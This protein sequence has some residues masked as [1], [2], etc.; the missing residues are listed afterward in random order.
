MSLA[1]SAGLPRFPGNVDWSACWWKCNHGRPA[2]HRQQVSET[3]GAFWELVQQLLRSEGNVWCFISGAS[4]AMNALGMWDRIEEGTLATRG[5]SRRAER[6][7]A[8]TGLPLVSDFMILHDPPFYVQLAVPGL[9]GRLHVV[10]IRNYSLKLDTTDRDVMRLAEE[11]RRVASDMVLALA[12]SK[13]PALRPTAASTS[14]DWW[15]L[16]FL[17]HTVLV[18]TNDEAL[19]LERDAVQGGRCETFRLGKC[20]E[21]V[22]SVDIRSCYPAIAMSH[23]LPA[24]LLHYGVGGPPPIYPKCRQ[25]V[26]TIGD[27]TIEICSPVAPCKLMG[28]TCYPIGTFRT[29]LCGPELWLV[30]NHGRIVKW[31]RWATYELDTVLKDYLR[32]LWHLR[33]RAIG[34]GESAAS[35]LYKAM[36]NS[37]VGKF[38]QHGRYWERDPDKVAHKPYGTWHA[39]DRAGQQHT[40]RAIAWEPQRLVDHGETADSCPAIAAWIYSAARVLLWERMV[41]A[42]LDNV[43]YI[44]TDSLFVNRNGRDRLAALVNNDNP[45]PGELRDVA[46]PGELEVY[47]IKHYRH[48]GVTKKAGPVGL[49]PAGVPKDVAYVHTVKPRPYKHGEVQPDGRVLPWEVE[50]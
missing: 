45:Q 29:V 16:S 8:K 34:E 23:G 5:H 37:I 47:G 24:R 25:P 4:R 41:C 40:Y 20:P 32:H 12:L 15:R 27:V 48:C 22:W 38:S 50:P 30:E 13:G 26:G 14:W 42:G 2:P 1:V 31:H 36:M 9:P 7:A 44:D 28:L 43:A 10:D 21:Q 46:G 6:V 35:S 39:N 33:E 11:T 3:R 19:K 17:R 18:H 49:R